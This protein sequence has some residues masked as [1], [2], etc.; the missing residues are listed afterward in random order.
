MGDLKRDSTPLKNKALAG[1]KIHGELMK[2]NEPVGQ[3]NPDRYKGERRNGV[4][5]FEGEQQ[6]KIPLIMVATYGKNLRLLRADCQGILPFFPSFIF[7][8]VSS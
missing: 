1:S 6:N 8:S 5:V 2:K 4:V 3:D 7:C